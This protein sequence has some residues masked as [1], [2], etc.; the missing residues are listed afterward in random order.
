[1]RLEHL[2]PM[3][4]SH[5]VCVV[6]RTFVAPETCMHHAD[7]ARRAYH[8]FVERGRARWARY[9]T[10]GY[11]PNANCNPVSVMTT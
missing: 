10:I 11:K 7:V 2:K 5:W 1:M 8:L 4:E 6:I 3:D 9:W